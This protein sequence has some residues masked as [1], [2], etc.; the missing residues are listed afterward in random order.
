MGKLNKENRW[1]Q[2]TAIIPYPP[3]FFMI[4]QMNE[5]HKKTDANP[6]VSKLRLGLLKGAEANL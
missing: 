5:L 2:L 3:F 6:N 4:R 1:V